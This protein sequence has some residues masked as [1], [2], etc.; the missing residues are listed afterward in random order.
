MKLN[1]VHFESNDAYLTDA[2]QLLFNLYLSN[3]HE[4]NENLI[5]LCIFSKK[6]ELLS[7]RQLFSSMTTLVNIF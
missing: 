5:Y 7:K 4:K 2:E 6:T 1:C 3:R